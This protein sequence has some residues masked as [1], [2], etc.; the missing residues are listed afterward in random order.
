MYLLKDRLS[1][2]DDDDDDDNAYSSEALQ[3][4]S[5]KVKSVKHNTCIVLSCYQGW[6]QVS[7]L[8]ETVIRPFVRERFDQE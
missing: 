5:D 2:D 1:D 3:C 7:A 4:Y 6:L 8:Y